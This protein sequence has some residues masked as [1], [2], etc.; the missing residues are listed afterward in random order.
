MRKAEE[1]H[2]G[3]KADLWEAS[4]LKKKPKRTWDEAALR[5]LKEK[6]HKKYRRDDVQ[7]IRWFTTHLRGKRLD[8][9]SRD[10]IDRLLTNRLTKATDDKRKRNMQLMRIIFRKAQHEWEWDDQ[11]P[12]AKGY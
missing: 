1:Y 6:A 7:R 9:V 2:D 12:A 3:L 4:R 10:M 8:E 5:W 11:L